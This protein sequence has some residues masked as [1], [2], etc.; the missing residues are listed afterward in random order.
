MEEKGS[1]GNLLKNKGEQGWCSAE[2]AHLS[3][4]CPGFDSQIWSRKWAELVGYHLCSKRFS[5]AYFGYPVSPKT[6]FDLS[7]VALE[8]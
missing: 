4:M 8:L 3:P 6:T 1:V 7:F 2:S 5:L